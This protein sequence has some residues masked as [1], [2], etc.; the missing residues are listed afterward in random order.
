MKRQAR[1]DFPFSAATGITARV[2]A[3]VGGGTASSIAH[4]VSMTM[5][6]SNFPK[7]DS[8]IL[9]TEGRSFDSIVAARG[10]VER[11]DVMDRGRRLHDTF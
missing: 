10:S 5:D 3:G 8:V 4:Q 7:A 6:R 1:M 9:G 11:G 2:E